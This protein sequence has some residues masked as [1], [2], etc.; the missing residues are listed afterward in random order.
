MMRADVPS[1]PPSVLPDWLR[2]IPFG[3]MNH[4]DA[5]RPI[6]LMLVDD[7]ALVR[8]G[9]RALLEMVGGI[10]VVG[11]AADG[12]Q[13]VEGVE[14]SRP[15]QVLMDLGLPRLNGLE[16]T[17]HIKKRWPHI[18]VVI[19]TESTD[20]DSVFRV[21]QAG[22][23]GYVL[24]DS[25]LSELLLAIQAARRGDTYLSPPIS[26]LLVERQVRGQPLHPPALD[27][28]TSR[29]REVLQLMAEG[30]S[31]RQIA[32]QLILSVKTVESHKAH[33]MQKLGF[34]RQVELVRFALRHFGPPSEPPLEQP[35]DRGEG[36]AATRQIATSHR[37]VVAWAG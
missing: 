36:L 16:A 4:P 13:A 24:K 25:D 23:C 26:K 34:R 12:R 15:D 8:Q 28:L 31:N 20:P 7:H 18:Q 21:L 10:Q 5:Q 14:T 29:E 6:R 9:L 17:I 30:Y 35:D 32:E 2:T 22:A 3:S 11:E 33:M 1:A 27:L 37:L 19:V